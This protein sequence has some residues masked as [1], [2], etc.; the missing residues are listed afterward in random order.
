MHVEYT[1]ESGAMLAITEIGA[2]QPGRWHLVWGHGWGQSGAAM[3]PLAETLRPFGHSSL[4][5]FPG[6]GK[7]PNPPDT[8]GTAEYADSV[9]AWL[10]SLSQPRVIWIGHSFGGRVGLQL[11]ARHPQLV[12]GMVLIAAA[13]LPRQ[14]S[15]SDQLRLRLRRTAFK[16]ARR[17][18]REGPQ[19]DALRKKFGSSDYQ[20]AGAL[21]P[22]FVRVVGEDLTDVARAVRC[23]TLLVYGTKD[24]ETPPEIGSRLQHLIPG[25]EL[26]LLDGFNHL[27]VLSEGR[28]QVALKIR[29]FLDTVNA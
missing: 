9:A 24:S 7:S 15:F 4:I 3:A 21:R 5:D 18:T 19:L 28:H 26:T 25:S 27:S 16:T 8:W 2:A 1:V 20:S 17:F 29:K 11:A 14:R 13:G 12:A 6:F 10:N 22:V 23:P